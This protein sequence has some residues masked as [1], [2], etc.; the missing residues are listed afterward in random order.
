MSYL[1]VIPNRERKVPRAVCRRARWFTV[2]AAL[3]VTGLTHAKAAEVADLEVTIEESTV[4]PLLNQAMAY[5]VVVRNHGPG[6]AAGVVVN[7]VLPEAALLLSANPSQGAV[8]HPDR[9]IIWTVDALPAGESASLTL[10]VVQ[11]L[12]GEAVLTSAVSAS[13]VDLNSFNNAAV[14]T[15]TTLLGG[16]PEILVGPESRDVLPGLP[17]SLIVSA[18]SELPL[19]YQWRL[20]GVNLPGATNHSFHVPVFQPENAGRYSVLVIND[21]G[22]VTSSQ[23]EVRPI[24]SLGVPFEDQFADRRLITGLV[25]LGVNQNL[26]ATV[27]P[28]EPAH[29]GKVVGKT[30]W[31][32]WQSLLNGIAT[33]RTTGSSIDT[34]LGVYTG[35]SLE[36]LVPVAA[37]DDGGG[38]LTSAVRFNAIAGQKYQIAVGGYDG[39]AGSFLF[40]LGLELTGERLPV[41]TSHPEGRTV[42][43]GTAATLTV[44]ATGTALTYQWFRNGVSLPGENASILQLPAVDFDQV[45]QYTVRVT[46]GNRSVMSKPASLQTFRPGPGESFQEVRAE[47]KLT[48]LLQSLLGILLGVDHQLI[49]PSVST[50]APKQGKQLKSPRPTGGIGILSTTRGYTGT[51]T[52]STYG[53]SSQQGEPGN[54][55]TPGGASQ[56]VA[57]EAP[58]SGVLV[59]DTAGS[60]FDT[61]LGVYTGSGSDFASLQ[62]VACDD[63][64][65]ADGITSRVIFNVQGGATYFVAVDGVNGQSGTVV[66]NYDLAI[67][68]QVTQQPEGTIAPVGTQIELTARVT[69]RPAPAG[70][71]LFNGTTLPGATN[72]TLIIPALQ[73]ENE[74]A[75]VLRLNNLA[76]QTE[77]SPVSLLIDAPLK[78]ASVDLNQAKQAKFRLIGQHSSIFLIQASTNLTDWVTIGTN[79]TDSGIL[80]YVDAG[81]TN[82]S[83]RFYR[84]VPLSQ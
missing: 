50:T 38:F 46:A 19:R 53:S 37:D 40:S 74:G 44:Q 65:G 7:N 35:E 17:L 63:N 13:S 48:D 62:P 43:P 45:G 49:T 60:N 20:N 11:P 9:P 78:L 28:G 51:H 47:D 4:L 32:T 18:A 84:A 21:L 68:P 64:S 59:L 80:S 71:W 5:S 69:G 30:K 52:F 15:V 41:I 55:E 72:L 16:L 33:I 26:N 83:V 34:V 6:A 67:A 24:L 73:S 23:A 42:P 66:L 22:V 76:G 39:A 36:T 81:S 1:S 77:T 82:H 54:C 2:L 79:Y 31:I 29:A 75:Y 27:E 3:L 70:Q 57:Y 25:V 58:E 14:S 56:W 10:S 61:T 12:L 8:Q